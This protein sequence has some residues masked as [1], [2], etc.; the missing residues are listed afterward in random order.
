[1]RRLPRSFPSAGHH[2]ANNGVFKN[3]VGLN[4]R[5]ARRKI[6]GELLGEYNIGGDAFEIER[7]FEEAGITLLSTFSGNSTIKSM[8]MRTRP[9]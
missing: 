5:P 9:T 2:I 1:L 6:P 3:V 8:D 4:D 7:L